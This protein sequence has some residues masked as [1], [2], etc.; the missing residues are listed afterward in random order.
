[1]GVQVGGD[2]AGGVH[3]P[4]QPAG[5]LGGR[6]FFEG[7]VLTVDGILPAAGE[8]DGPVAGG[9]RDLASAVDVESEGVEIHRGGHGGV[10]A[11]LQ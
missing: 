8:G 6:A 4:L 1:V 10:V 11:G 9:G 5:D 7:D 2:E 3:L